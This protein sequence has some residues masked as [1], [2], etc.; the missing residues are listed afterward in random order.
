[1]IFTEPN[2][3]EQMIFDATAKRGGKLASM[4]RK[5]ASLYE[6]KLLGNDLHPA[7]EES[8]QRLR[9]RKEPVTY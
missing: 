7:G 1:M 9:F 4:V 5:D 6:G 3:V 2:S 8:G